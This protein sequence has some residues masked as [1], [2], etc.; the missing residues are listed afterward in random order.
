[1]PGRSFRWPNDREQC[2]LP[3]ERPY[4]TLA[5]TTYAN[6]GSRQR[7]RNLFLGPYCL[8][9]RESTSVRNGGK[10]SVEFGAVQRDVQSPRGRLVNCINLGH[11]EPTPAQ[12]AGVTT[13]WAARK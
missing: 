13:L 11:S 2:C 1:M 7:G 6:D 10:I 4:S 3:K 9:A 5:T 12:R 8:R